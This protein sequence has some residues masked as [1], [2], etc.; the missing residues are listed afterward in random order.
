MYYDCTG[1]LASSGN[2]FSAS[3][4]ASKHEILPNVNK[5]VFILT[6][7]GVSAE[8]VLTERD[9]VAL[10]NLIHNFSD[11]WNE[12]GLG[13]GFIP[14]ELNK[15]KKNP[16]LFMSAPVS[17]LINLLSQWVQWPTVNHPTKPTLTAFCETLRSSLVGLGSLAEKVEKEMICSLRGKK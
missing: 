13:L 1:C 14:S 11:K 7:L 10:L 16:S 15:I 5:S 8:Q 2:I 9:I 3:L 6:V 12:I 17:F 4:L